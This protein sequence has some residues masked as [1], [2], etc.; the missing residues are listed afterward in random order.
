MWLADLHTLWTGRTYN[1]LQKG[2]KSAFPEETEY[3]I[4]DLVLASTLAVADSLS[5]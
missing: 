4:A 3:T 2:Y 1:V 5:P